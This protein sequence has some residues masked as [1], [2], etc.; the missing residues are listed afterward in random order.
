M[1]CALKKTES[2]WE[3]VASQRKV[4]VVCTALCFNLYGRKSDQLS[5]NL[6]T[7]TLE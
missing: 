1:A 7:A 4:S 6:D 5:G 3:V 2:G